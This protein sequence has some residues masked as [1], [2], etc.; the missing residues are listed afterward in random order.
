LYT[1]SGLTIPAPDGEYSDGTDVYTVT[2]GLGEI[3]STSLC[4]SY[5]TTTTTSTTT[6]IPSYGLSIFYAS[7]AVIASDV[8]LYYST[9]GG[10]TWTLG[11]Q[12]NPSVGFPNYNV[13]STGFNAGTNI[14]IGFTDTSDANIQFGSGQF[15]GDFVTQCGLTN[16]YQVINISANT[17]V[18]LNIGVSGGN[19]VPCSATT[20]TT[21][22]TTTVAPTTT[23]T[24]STTTAPET[25]TTTT[26]STTTIVENLFFDFS[27]GIGGYTVSAI[28][29]NGVTPTLTSGT[30][31][32]FNTDGHGY[33]T[34]QIGTNETLNI[35]ISPYVVNGCITVTDS[36][37]NVFQQ[38]INS[39]GT[40]TFSGLTIDNITPV[41]VIGADNVC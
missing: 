9:D 3:T 16:P 10:L 23:T 40:Y 39:A 21:T 1:D 26:T 36:A 7:E 17:D 5:S 20:T 15:S 8:R 31:V 32:P 22:S 29:V 12:S 14:L 25:S 35:T 34:N 24:T 28:N 30:D 37:S 38:N 18:Y 41:N 13:F 27:S 2:G 33:N 6:A 19:Y 11:V 4:S